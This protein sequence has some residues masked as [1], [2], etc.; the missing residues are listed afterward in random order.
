MDITQFIETYGKPALKDLLNI[1]IIRNPSYHSPEWR[2]FCIRHGI[3]KHT[4]K[5]VTAYQKSRTVNIIY[6]Y[7]EGRLTSVGREWITNIR[8]VNGAK[9]EIFTLR[10]TDQQL[11]EWRIS[12]TNPNQG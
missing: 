6:K 9:R 11:E 12:E 5:T 3:I 4:T 1:F 8:L 2:M 10:Y 7:V